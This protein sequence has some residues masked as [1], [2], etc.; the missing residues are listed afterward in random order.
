MHLN[1]NF[2]YN[3]VRSHNNVSRAKVTQSTELSQHV[4]QTVCAGHSKE[5]HRPVKCNT[6]TG[7]SHVDRDCKS[8]E[9]DRKL[10]CEILDSTFFLFLDRALFRLDSTFWLDSM[11]KLY[12][13]AVQS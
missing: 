6:G 11:L 8:F 9:K 12:H 10:F 5:K 7:K 4:K 3:F 2:C 1:V 13:A